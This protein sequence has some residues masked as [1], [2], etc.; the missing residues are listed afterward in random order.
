MGK[1]AGKDVGL[2]CLTGIGDYC[3]RCWTEFTTLTEQERKN[4]EERAKYIR[5]L[6]GRKYVKRNREYL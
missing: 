1:K 6:K 2:S 5:K 3:K 4:L